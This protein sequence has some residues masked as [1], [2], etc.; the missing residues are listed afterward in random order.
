MK[1]DLWALFYCSS[2]VS[3]LFDSIILGEQ[4]IMFLMVCVCVFIVTLEIPL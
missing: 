3:K 2:T 1:K 4:K